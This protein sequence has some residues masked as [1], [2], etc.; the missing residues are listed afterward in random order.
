MFSH[1]IF[2][3]SIIKQKSSDDAFADINNDIN[4]NLLVDVKV[5]SPLVN[6]DLSGDN[7]LGNMKVMEINDI[8]AEEKKEVKVEEPKVEEKPQVEESKIEEKS[9]EEVKR[10]ELINKG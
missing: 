10:E 3:N 8:F 2:V 4:K 5:E 7:V 1:G 6:I 9:Q